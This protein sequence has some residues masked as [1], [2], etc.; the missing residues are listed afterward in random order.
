MSDVHGTKE[1]QEAIKGV[2]ALYKAVKELTKDGAQLADLLA[3]ASKYQS[4]AEFKAKLD[5]AMADIANAEVEMKELSAKDYLDLAAC[6][7]DE[8][9][10][11]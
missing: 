2:F 9:K 11:M 6:V 3:L 8:M 5:A 4:D 10:A 1:M 7:I